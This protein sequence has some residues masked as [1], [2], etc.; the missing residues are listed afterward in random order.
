MMFSLNCMNHEG[1]LHIYM[2][3]NLSIYLF[4]DTVYIHR[5]IHT[6]KS[7]N[8]EREREGECYVPVGL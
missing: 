6:G 4:K 7:R 2:E 3:T 1:Y 5:Y 8:R